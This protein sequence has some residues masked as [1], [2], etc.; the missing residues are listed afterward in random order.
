MLGRG[1]HGKV[2]LCSKKN[3]PKEFYAM[4]IIKKQHIIDS[5]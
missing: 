5:K 2:I 3:N 1:A 4:K